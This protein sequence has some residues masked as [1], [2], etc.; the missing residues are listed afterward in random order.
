MDLCGR[1]VVPMG[2]ENAMRWD[3]RPG[4]YEVWY[5][6]MNLPEE[7]VGFWLRYTLDA[8]LP[9]RG[10]P[11]CELWAHHFDAADPRRSFG[12]K[13]VHSIEALSRDGIVGI[14]E[15][16]YREGHLRGAIEAEGR[17]VSWDL[18][19]RPS[20]TSV[21]LAP[22]PVRAAGLARTE[23][24][25]PNVA[26]RFSGTLRAGGRAFELDGAPG[27]QGHLFGRKHAEAWAW[28]HCSAWDGG[29]DA[30]VDGVA[31]VLRR[32]R[33]RPLTALFLRVRGEDLPLATLAGLLRARG[34]LAF[35]R[36]A[37]RGGS[38]R[39]LVE[40]EAR[41]LPE[42]ALQVRYLDPDGEE[43]LCAHSAVADCRVALRWAD[44]RTETL[45]ARG[46]ANLEFGGRSAFPGVRHGV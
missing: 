12:L 36:F 16:R 11:R 39:V 32:G 24:R 21:H 23:V 6:T 27:H 41:L 10:T 37:F 34:E 38:R 7:Q 15:A 1:L 5:L 25:F 17:S 19:Y 9:G 40:G 30:T 44:G 3:G 33:S 2:R 42:S 45:A 26:T 35:P 43:S 18:R 8:P 13:S 46:T 31:A 28:L 4:R 22:W 29:A 20:P 14:G